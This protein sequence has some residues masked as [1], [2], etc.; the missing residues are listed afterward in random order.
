M[1]R[2]IHGLLAF[3]IN[4]DR[5]KNRTTEKSSGQQ[6]GEINDCDLRVT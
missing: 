2:L 4:S 6:V 3:S 1:T 5:D